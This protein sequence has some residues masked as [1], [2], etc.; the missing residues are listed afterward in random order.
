MVCLLLLLLP[1]LAGIFSAF[2]QSHW[3]NTNTKQVRE[4]DT[5]TDTN[6]EKEKL[7]AEEKLLCSCGAM[8]SVTAAAAASIAE[9]LGSFFLC[10]HFGSLIL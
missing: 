8:E 2:Q 4:K 1:L 9:L 5:H 10:T 6:R 7:K 3:A